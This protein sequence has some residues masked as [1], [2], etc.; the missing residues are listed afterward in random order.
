[1]KI[2]R[3][4]DFPGNS[5]VQSGNSRL[6]R[7]GFKVGAGGCGYIALDVPNSM[8]R[9]IW[10]LTGCESDR[11]RCDIRWFSSSDNQQGQRNGDLNDFQLVLTV[12]IIDFI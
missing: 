8:L 11:I 5:F 6:E 1:M 2:H 12:L 3:L 4:C 7:V 9:L 10:I